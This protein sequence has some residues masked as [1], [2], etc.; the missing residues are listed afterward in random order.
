M[1]GSERKAQ[2]NPEDTKDG[3][4]ENR[5]AGDTKDGVG[6]AVEWDTSRPSVDGVSLVSRRKMP[7][8]EDVEDNMS[9][10]RM[11]KSEECGSLGMWWNSRRKKALAACVADPSTRHMNINAMNH[12]KIVQEDATGS[13]TVVKI[14]MIGSVKFVKIVF[15]QSS[16]RKTCKRLEKTDGTTNVHR[17]NKFG[18]LNKPKSRMEVER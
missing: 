15:L 8:A 1:N 13:V 2:A 7:T 14:D 11:E 5:N 9:Q 10:R 6:R 3:F 17:S 18:V 4:R 12:V 16:K